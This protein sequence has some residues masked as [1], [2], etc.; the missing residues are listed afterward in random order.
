MQSSGVEVEVISHKRQRYRSI[1]T[2][3][4]RTDIVPG[5]LSGSVDLSLHH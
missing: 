5:M 2:V 1:A 3:S 4:L